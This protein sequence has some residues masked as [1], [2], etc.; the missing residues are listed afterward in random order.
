MKV[1]GRCTCQIAGAHDDSIC[2]SSSSL[3]RRFSK[4][5]ELTSP[6][7]SPDAEP[8]APKARLLLMAIP[9]CSA[10]VCVCVCGLIRAL[11]SEAP[12]AK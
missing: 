6:P 8:A 12:L 7:E 11:G 10:T 2:L 9:I 1:L 3:S 5:L 4:I